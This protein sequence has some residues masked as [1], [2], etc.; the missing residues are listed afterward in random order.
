MIQR[1]LIPKFLL[2]MI[3]LQRNEEI[4]ISNN[5]NSLADFG[6]FADLFY[7]NFCHSDFYDIFKLFI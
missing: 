1:I 7:K 3:D 6:N 5:I 2:R 4:I